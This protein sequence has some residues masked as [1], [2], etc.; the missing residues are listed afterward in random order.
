MADVLKLDKNKMIASTV[1]SGWYTTLQ[2]PAFTKYYNIGPA[3]N[4]SARYAT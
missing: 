4:I 1:C 2:R 3:A